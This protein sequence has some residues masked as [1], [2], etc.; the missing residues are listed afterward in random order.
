[1]LYDSPGEAWAV[2]T[3][4]VRQ[5]E[6]LIDRLGEDFSRWPDPQQRQAA[7]ELLAC[8]KDARALIEEARVLREALSAPAVG[9]PD[10]LADRIAAAARRLAEEEELVVPVDAIQPG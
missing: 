4:D 2:R 9:A 5:F 8:S 3:M 7:T 6:D 10:G 1:M